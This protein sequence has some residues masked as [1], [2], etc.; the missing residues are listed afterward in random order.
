MGTNE[1]II[2]AFG[3]I[4]EVVHETVNGLTDKQLTYRPAK[5]AN[6]IAWLLWHLTRVQDDHMS[7]L[8]DHEQIWT[9][10]DWYDKFG[11]P[12]DKVATGYGQSSSE[13]AQV[14]T[15]A[16]LLL[17]YHDAVYKETVRFIRTL[18]TDDYGEIVDRN[19][20]P[21]VTMAVRIISVIS[22]DLQHC[23]QAA[24]VRGLLS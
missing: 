7:E 17:E 13:V 8:A 12:F 21:P 15:G 1:I 6:S 3:R 9:A 22:D 19:W 18:K 2:D 16:D 14:K 5:D 24:Y 10:G 20:N 4:R 11:L 23:G